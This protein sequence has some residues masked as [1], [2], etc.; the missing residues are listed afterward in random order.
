M[1]SPIQQ[2]QHQLSWFSMHGVRA[3]DLAV[4]P[5]GGRPWI[6][7]HQNISHDAICARLRWCRAENANGANIYIRPHRRSAVPVVFL[8]DVTVAAATELAQRHPALVH[9]TSTNRC[10]V[11]LATDN[12]LTEAERYAVQRCCAARMVQRAIAKL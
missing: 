9:E 1:Q 5:A 6:V 10:H 7:A 4:Q 12:P 3:L 8:D 2:T 11:W